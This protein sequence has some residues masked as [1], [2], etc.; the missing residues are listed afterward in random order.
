MLSRIEY[1]TFANYSPRGQSEDSVK[2]RNICG[3]IK[4]GRIELL[5]QVTQRLSNP[6]CQHLTPFIDG[7]SL[8][9]PVPRS[10]PIPDNA[11]WPAK[12][13]CER[14]RHANFGQDILPCIQRTT[15]IKKSSSSEGAA[16][17][18]TV[19]EQYDSLVVNVPENNLFGPE[20]ITLV[21]D[22]LTLGRTSFA[23]AWRIHEAFPNAEIRLFAII[24][25]KGFEPELTKFVDPEIGQITY[26]PST[27]K[28]SRHP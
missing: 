2:S 27:G 3:G 19:Q 6:N 21:D 4:R 24:R 26:N 17:R 23:C 14:L 20:K 13:I 10:S 12:V 16:G 28:T 8:L 25:T 11:L 7:G 5:D 18:P 1:A 22:V 15:A 9:V